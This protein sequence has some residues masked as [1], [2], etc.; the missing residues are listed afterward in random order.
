MTATPETV[1]SLR[2]ATLR[3]GD[4][5]L[6]EGLDLDVHRGEVIAVLG[7]N[8]SGKSSLL[9][10]I[11]GQ[12]PLSSGAE[13]LLGRP[14][15][16]GDRRIGYVPQQTMADDGLPLR[17]RDLVGLGVDGQR[18]GV[19]LPSRRRWERI[20]ELLASVGAQRYADSP[21]STLSGGEQ[22]R[23]R[24]AQALAA[25]PALLLCDEP[26]LSLDLPHQAMLVDLVD[27]AR[28]R[29]DL[30]VLFVT[31]DV[32]P[33]LGIVDRVLYIANSRFLIGTVDEVMRSDV[34]TELYGAPVDVFRHRGRVIV[35]GVPE[36][37]PHHAEAPADPATGAVR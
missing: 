3:F 19:P 26:L 23:L 9:R 27:D 7:S 8:G 32:N 33:V 22:Q 28:R 36:H 17:G 30:G 15:R 16:R 14:V 18:W 37:V 4:R 21:V 24:M 35:V 25:D 10:T 12:L 11:L 5:T 13:S 2:D 20:D 31:H 34:L 1:L 29:L 6:W